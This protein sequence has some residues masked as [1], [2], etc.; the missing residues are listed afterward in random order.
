MRSATLIASASSC[1]YLKIQERMTSQ[2]EKFEATAFCVLLQ[3]KS[4]NTKFNRNCIVVL[5]GVLAD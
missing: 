2:C 3:T 4:A 1:E 5:E